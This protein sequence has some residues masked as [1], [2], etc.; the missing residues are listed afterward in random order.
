MPEQGV[1]LDLNP[2]LLMAQRLSAAACPPAVPRSGAEWLR[3]P[4]YLAK[5]TVEAWIA[6]SAPSIGAALAYYTAFSLAPLLLI[7]IAVAGAIFGDEAARGEVFGQL[8]QLVGPEGAEMIQSVLAGSRSP[9]TGLLASVVGGATLLL[10]ATSVF[11]ELQAAL[12]RIW[13]APAVSHQGFLLLLRSRVLSFGLVLALG[14]LLLVSL[15]IGAALTAVGRWW[16]PMFAGWE[17]VL[18]AVNLIAGFVIVTVLFALIYKWLPRVRVAWRDVW[19]GA[20]VTAILFSAGKYAIGLYLGT[21]GVASTFGAA[22]SL[23]VVLVWV[24]YSA[25]IFL[26]GAEFTAVYAHTHGSKQVPA[27]PAPPPPSTL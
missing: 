2:H 12:D 15:A 16:G 9:A 10:G 19:V 3:G 6:D 27:P 4:W 13:R 25:Q 14:F 23:A 18:Q 8:R 24:Y 1:A 26:L 7:V 21:S 20:L 22:G 11:A 17:H 5:A